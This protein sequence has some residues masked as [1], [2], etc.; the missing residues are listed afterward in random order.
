MCEEMNMDDLLY[1]MDKQ[2]RERREWLRSAALAAFYKTIDSEL[3]NISANCVPMER[4]KA[5]MENIQ[6]A[7]SVVREI[8]RSV[9]G[10]YE[11][12]R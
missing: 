5:S 4:I 3:S 11:D 9:G 7:Y 10:D 8:L 2:S 1:E 12:A 6:G